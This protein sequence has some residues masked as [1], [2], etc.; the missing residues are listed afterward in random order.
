MVDV[1]RFVPARWSKVFN[2]HIEKRQKGCTTERTSAVEVGV[3]GRP[4]SHDLL[5]IHQR[6]AGLT[7]RTT[8]NL[9]LQEKGKKKI[10]QTVD[11][12]SV[13]LP[14]VVTTL[15][16]GCNWGWV[17][18]GRCRGRHLKCEEICRKLPNHLTDGEGFIY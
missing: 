14:G 17:G 12:D 2:F 10:K 8:G 4:A 16:P 15:P 13:D 6:V 18:S 9:N 5:V 1:R 11:H 3:V 7:Q